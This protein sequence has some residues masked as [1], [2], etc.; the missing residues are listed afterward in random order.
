VPIWLNDCDTH[1]AS[2]GG[3]VFV[4]EDGD[5]RLAAVMVGAGRSNNTAIPLAVWQELLDGKGCE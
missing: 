5:L 1:P 4:Q 3:P 2:S